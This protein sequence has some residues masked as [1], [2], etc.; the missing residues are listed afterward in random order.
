LLCVLVVLG[1]E[2]RAS[3]M[4]SKDLKS[5]HSTAWATRTDHFAVLI[6]IIVVLAVHCGIYKSSC[7]ISNT[8]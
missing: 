3:Y 7:N 8:L 2:L 4:Q 6:I 5:R 1:F